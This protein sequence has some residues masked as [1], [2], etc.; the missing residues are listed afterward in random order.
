MTGTGGRE[1][2]RP[3][4]TPAY[5]GTLAAILGLCLAA[6][7][8]NGCGGSSQPPA[9]DPLLA[10]ATQ[11]CRQYAAQQGIPNADALCDTGGEWVRRWLTEL[12]DSSVTRLASVP[13]A[14]A[15]V[16]TPQPSLTGAGGQGVRP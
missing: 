15:P 14:P 16:T 11:A 10:F 6:L 7:F 13:C 3:M 8:G 1:T 12:R 2:I 9:Q 5:L 4:S